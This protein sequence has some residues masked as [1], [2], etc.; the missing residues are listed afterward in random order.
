MDAGARPRTRRPPRRWGWAVSRFERAIVGAL[1]HI[2]ETTADPYI[3]F[4]AHD[5][6]VRIRLRAERR[7]YRARGRA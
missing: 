3:V 1:R 5:E 4:R 6:M 7:A 2:A